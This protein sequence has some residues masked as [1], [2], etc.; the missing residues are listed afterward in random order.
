MYGSSSGAQ[1]LFFI[2]FSSPP[3][4]HRKMNQS[5]SVR[6][7]HPAYLARL[8]LS[9]NFAGMISPS[10]HSYNRDGVIRSRHTSFPGRQTRAG[11]FFLAALYSSH[12]LSR[13]NTVCFRVRFHPRILFH[14]FGAW[15]SPS[16]KSARLFSYQTNGAAA[17]LIFDRCL[18][19]FFRI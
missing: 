5:T 2:F 19:I 18:W 9:K 6:V 4:H 11:C 8:V 15:I 16:R 1:F 10:R 12:W 14:Y 17:L 13:S 7:L 3:S